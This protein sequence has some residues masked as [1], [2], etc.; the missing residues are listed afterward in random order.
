M[1]GAAAVLA[2]RGRWTAARAPDGCSLGE[3]QADGRTRHH[4][5][6]G[7]G[8]HVQTV[9]NF[10]PWSERRGEPGGRWLRERSRAD[11]WGR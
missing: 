7:V 8:V 9:P 10:E 2:R 5:Y 6:G 1:A 3:G 11:T 4:M